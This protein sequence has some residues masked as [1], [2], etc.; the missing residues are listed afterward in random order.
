MEKHLD[1]THISLANANIASASICHL[2]R[3]ATLPLKLKLRPY[4]LALSILRKTP[5]S[6]SAPQHF[7]KK[8]PK[9][10]YVTIV[11]F[12]REQ[13]ISDIYPYPF[14]SVEEVGR[15]FV[16]VFINRSD[17]LGCGGG[18]SSL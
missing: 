18:S 9:E 7:R 3:R 10:C 17:H 15:N 2:S 11:T 4:N 6:S 12:Y 14:G 16:K 13:L 8:E 5:A 1:T